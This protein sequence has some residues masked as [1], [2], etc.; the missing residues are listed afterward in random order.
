MIRCYSVVSSIN[1]SIISRAF[2]GFAV[3][4]SSDRQQTVYLMFELYIFHSERISFRFALQ[5]RIYLIR[6]N[7]SNKI[8]FIASAAPYCMF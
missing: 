2:G 6:K 3:F 8:L 5:L 7:V 4:F 1:D